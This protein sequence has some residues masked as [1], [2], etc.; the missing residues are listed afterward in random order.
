M[1]N[2]DTPAISVRDLWLEF[3]A[4]GANAALPV[5]EAVSF[6][7][8]PGEFVCIVGASGCGKSTLLNV[9]GGFL[10]ATRGSAIVEGEPVAGPDRRRIFVFQDNGVFPWLTVQENVGFGLSRAAPGER[11]RSRALHRDGRRDGIRARL[12]ARALG[13][14]APARRD[15][16]RSP[17]PPTSSTWTSPSARSTSSPASRCAAI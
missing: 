1:G 10:N 15:R 11:A 4:K 3:P 6:D 9:I 14:H 16:A 12:S 2:A 17:P 5:L 13:R 7:V 8:M